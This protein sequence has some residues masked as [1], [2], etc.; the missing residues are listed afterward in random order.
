MKLEFKKWLE[1]ILGQ[2][3]DQ[4]DPIPASQ[5]P[6]SLNNNAFPSYDIEEPRPI[7]AKKKRM[8]KN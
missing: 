3:V 6:A 5:Y 4:A 7:W 2:P 8:K 1:S